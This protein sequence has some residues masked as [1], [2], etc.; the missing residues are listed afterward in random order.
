MRVSEQYILE[1]FEEAVETGRIKAFFQPIVRTMTGRVCC[2]EALARWEDATHGLLSQADFIPVLERHDLIYRLD[3]AM[4][5]Q[6]CAMYRR[7]KDDGRE[8][9]SFS[10]N[11]SRLDF[12]KPGSFEAIDRALDAH[13]VPREAIKIEVTESVLMAERERFQQVFRTLQG[14][15]YSVWVDDFGSGYSSLGMLQDYRFNLLKIDMVF[16][17]NASPESRQLVAAIVKTAKSLGILTLIEGVETE[18]QA[19]FIRSIGGDTIQGFYYS[20]P[21]EAEKLCAYLSG[22][23]VES[24]DE[25]PYW[26]VICHFDLLTANPFEEK[27]TARALMQSDIPLALIDC[28]WAGAITSMPTTPIWPACNRSALIPSR[29]WSASTTTRSAR[30]ITR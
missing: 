2:A 21:L 7:L 30:T 25:K 14:A 15:G 23:R 19:Q 6:A 12:T 17:R 29:R 18:E 28:T 3:M 1:H 5:E 16:M 24:P 22:R 27:K 20:E 26:N 11:F 10:V 9:H 13:R 4:L 8:L